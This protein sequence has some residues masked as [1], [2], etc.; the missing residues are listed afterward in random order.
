MRLVTRQ[1]DLLDL[2][3]G[4][5]LLPYL[6]RARPR[7]QVPRFHDV[8]ATQDLGRDRR[9][10][11]GAPERTGENQIRNNLRLPRNLQHVFQLPFALRG[12][13]PVAVR[14][15]GLPLFGFPVAQNIDFHV[16][17]SRPPRS[18]RPSIAIFPV[19]RSAVSNTLETSP[20]VRRPAAARPW[21]RPCYG[22]PSPTW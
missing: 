10:L 3:V 15:P 9:C 7:K 1:Q 11:L 2:I 6:L 4:A 12:E 14:E 5:D 21:P 17:C 8:L 18:A 22:G 16:T 19:V 20:P 13:F